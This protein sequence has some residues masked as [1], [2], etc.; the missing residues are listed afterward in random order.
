[1]SMLAIDGAQQSG[2]GTI[3]DRAVWCPRRV[4]RRQVVID[5]L[6]PMRA[7]TAEGASVRQP[8]P[9]A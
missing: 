9:I 5:G 7:Q 6:G 1:M 3:A 8:T 4:E 2:S